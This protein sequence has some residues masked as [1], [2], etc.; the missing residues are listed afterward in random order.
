MTDTLDRPSQ[1]ER[2]DNRREPVTLPE[3]H[4]RAASWHARELNL[5]LAA[6]VRE[7]VEEKLHRDGRSA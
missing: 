7:A 1:A 4:I 5:D 6:Y 3:S 2:Y